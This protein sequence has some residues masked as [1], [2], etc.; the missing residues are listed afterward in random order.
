M[1]RRERKEWGYEELYIEWIDDL[2]TSKT[3]SC[4]HDVMGSY[5]TLHRSRRWSLVVLSRINTEHTALRRAV[6]HRDVIKLYQT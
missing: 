2:K 5:G 6:R 3:R 4:C 1:E